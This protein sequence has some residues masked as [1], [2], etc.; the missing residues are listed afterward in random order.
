MTDL[1][2]DAAKSRYELPVDGG[3]AFATY[4]RKGDALAITHTHTPP[5]L[6]GRGIASRLVKAMLADIRQ[7]GLKVIPQCSFVA[8]YIARHPEEQ[9]LLPDT[10]R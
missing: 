7:Q 8:D 4:A 2:H 3:V 10:D 1:V 9:D 5:E 6:Q